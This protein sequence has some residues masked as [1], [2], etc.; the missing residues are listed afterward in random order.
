MTAGF[1]LFSNDPLLTRDPRKTP[2]AGVVSDAAG[3]RYY[4][5]DF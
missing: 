3:Q 1:I 4:L 5:F 2:G